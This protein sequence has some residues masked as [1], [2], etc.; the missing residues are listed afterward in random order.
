MS[1]SQAK[2]RLFIGNVPRKWAEEDLEKVVT[3]VGRGVTLVE[4]KKVCYA[5]LFGI[6][7]RLI[8]ELLMAS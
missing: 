8:S 5:G 6:K 2:H 4:L 7:Y 1:A 3:K